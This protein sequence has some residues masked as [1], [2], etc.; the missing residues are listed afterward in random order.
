[1]YLLVQRQPVSLCQI[2]N[3]LS[4]LLVKLWLLYVCVVCVDWH[5][6]DLAKYQLYRV[7]MKLIMKVPRKVHCAP[8]TSH[9]SPGLTALTRCNSSLYIT[10]KHPYCSTVHIHRVIKFVQFSTL[11]C[12]LYFS[13]Y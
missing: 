12:S 11:Q 6:G 8:A 2:V 4:I 1:M 3:N 13:S 5:K 7:V 10:I 9:Q